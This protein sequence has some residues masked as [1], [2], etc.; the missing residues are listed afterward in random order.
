M[1]PRFHGVAATLRSSRG[2]TEFFSGSMASGIRSHA[3]RCV[4]LAAGLGAVELLSAV[5]KLID[6]ALLGRKH[7]FII[8]PRQRHVDDAASN[9]TRLFATVLRVR[10]IRTAL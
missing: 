4:F 8:A 7:I 2:G 6:S 9:T 3:P 5:R 10:G 1:P